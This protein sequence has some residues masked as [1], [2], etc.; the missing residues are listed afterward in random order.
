LKALKANTH[1]SQTISTLKS[2]GGHLNLKAI[3]N[4]FNANMTPLTVPGAFHTEHAPHFPSDYEAL[5]NSVRKLTLQMKGKKQ[6]QKTRFASPSSSDDGRR[7]RD[8]RQDRS[9]SHAGRF[10]RKVRL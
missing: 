6:F 5:A 7:G 1:Y 10:P 3:Q 4:A 9:R 8:G 2:V